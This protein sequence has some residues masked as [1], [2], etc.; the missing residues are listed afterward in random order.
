MTRCRRAMC[1]P[2]VRAWWR[3]R[4]SVLSSLRYVTLEGFFYLYFWLILI[5]VRN[6]QKS[7]T[8]HTSWLFIRAS[9]CGQKCSWAASY[10]KSS[11]MCTLIVIIIIIII[12]YL[13]PYKFT[14]DALYLDCIVIQYIL[15]CIT[16]H[17]DLFEIKLCQKNSRMQLR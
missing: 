5:C 15:Y 3:R 13:M 12:I 10:F 9:W 11:M 8:P 17:I 4:L 6:A 2:A 16:I 1:P 14:R 7:T